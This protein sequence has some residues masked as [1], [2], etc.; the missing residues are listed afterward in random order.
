MKPRGRRKEFVGV[1]TSD[2]MTKTRVVTIE[3]MARDPEIGKYVRRRLKVKAHDEREGARVEKR[4]RIVEVVER[5]RRPVEVR[6]R[7]A[8]ESAPEIATI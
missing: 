8:A 6:R 3:W 4:W 2:R 1:V 7:Y 5:S